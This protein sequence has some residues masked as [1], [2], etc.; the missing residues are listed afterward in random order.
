MFVSYNKAYKAMW[1]LSTMDKLNYLPNKYILFICLKCFRLNIYSEQ[2]AN[3]RYCVTHIDFLN[4][5]AIKFR[6]WDIWE[7]KDKFSVCQHIRKTWSCKI[8]FNKI[9]TQ[10]TSKLP[11]RTLTNF[12][13]FFFLNCVYERFLH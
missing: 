13:S 2:F 11:S 10:K 7:I 6:L 9:P 4:N 8:L 5:L 12:F 1:V 3:L